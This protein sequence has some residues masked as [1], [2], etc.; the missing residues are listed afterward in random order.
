MF[1]ALLRFDSGNPE[2]MFMWKKSIII[3]KYPRNYSSCV[4]LDPQFHMVGVHLG[5]N[6]THMISPHRNVNY[7]MKRTW[8]FK[9]YGSSF[10]LTTSNLISRIHKRY[11]KCKERMIELFCG[12]FYPLQISKCENLQYFI[13]GMQGCLHAIISE[14]KQLTFTGVFWT[15]WFL[16]FAL[17]VGWRKT[18]RL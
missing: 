18:F 8:I 14:R 9:T 12:I 16:C 10:Y 1:A 6:T 11:W 17:L 4:G 7:A 15:F 13:K 2:N 5:F 3:R